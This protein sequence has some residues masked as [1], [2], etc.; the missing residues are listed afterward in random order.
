VHRQAVCAVIRRTGWD[1]TRCAVDDL[2]TLADQ[3][4]VVTGRASLSVDQVRHPLGFLFQQITAAAEHAAATGYVPR[5]ERYRAVAAERAQRLARQAQ[6]RQEAAEL[7][8]RLASPEETAA[9]EAIIA[10]MR[11]QFPS[12]PRARRRR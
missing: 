9:R 1:V 8:A 3:R 6:E 4:N 10:A 7:R 5:A 2:V 11:A 12:S